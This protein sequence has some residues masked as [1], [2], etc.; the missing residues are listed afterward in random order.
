MCFINRLVQKCCYSIV[1]NEI[2]FILLASRYFIQ[3][4]RNI[5]SGTVDT[6]A[7]Q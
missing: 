3:I 4:I 7:K 2:S 6:L 5:S 1:S